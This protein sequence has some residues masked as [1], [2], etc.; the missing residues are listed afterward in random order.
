MFMGFLGL[1]GNDINSA[2]KKGSFGE[3]TIIDN[4]DSGI[5][6]ESLSLS[7]SRIGPIPAKWCGGNIIQ[8]NK[9]NG[10]IEVP[11]NRKLIGAIF[12]NKSYESFNEKFP[13]SQHIAYD[14]VG[15]ETRTL[16][17]INGNSVPGASIFNI[18]NRTVKGGSPK[19]RITTLKVSWSLE[20][21]TSYF[22]VDVLAAIDQEINDTVDLIY[23][24][25]SGCTS[26]NSEEIFT[27][28]V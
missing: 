24:S 28:E 10:S 22:G 21:A 9:L 11:C 1:R 4:I 14:L 7:D 19:S 12:F 23:V 3:N 20:D 16:S 8:I 15:H 5:W 26:T 6:P 25:T 27:D 13:R 18:G 17:T 2:W